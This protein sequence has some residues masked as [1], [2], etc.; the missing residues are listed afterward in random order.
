MT[1][2]AEPVEQELVAEVRE[3]RE[4]VSGP[5]H[6]QL[7]RRGLLIGGLA[8]LVWSQRY[9]IAKHATGRILTAF[10]R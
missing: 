5:S 1:V 9:R 6:A 4:E 2:Q 3:I 7:L 10:T 8:G